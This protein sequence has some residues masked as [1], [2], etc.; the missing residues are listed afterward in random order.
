[1]TN[2]RRGAPRSWAR[3]GSCAPWRVSQATRDLTRG[4]ALASRWRWSPPPAATSSAG[5]VAPV[6]SGRLAPPR[7]GGTPSGLMACGLPPWALLPPLGPLLSSWCLP[8]WRLLACASTAP[9]SASPPGR[10]GGS[11]RAAAAAA[12]SRPAPRTRTAC[13]PC[14]PCRR[15]CRNPC[16]PPCRRCRPCRS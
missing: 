16:R 9:P 2:P 7:H 5:R 8:P 12:R 1:M 4:R 10:R 13:R 14:R 6:A 3:P 15:P 11:Q